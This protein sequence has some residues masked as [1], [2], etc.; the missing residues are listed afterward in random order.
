[1]V[2]KLQAPT[3]SFVGLQCPTAGGFRIESVES[4][5]GHA[6][7]EAFVYQLWPWRDIGWK[8]VETVDIHNVALE[9]GGLYRCQQEIM[10]QDAAY[11]HTEDACKI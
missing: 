8:L 4:F 5:L 2:I 9:F 6:H 10:Q 7:I 3:N 1:M 11:T